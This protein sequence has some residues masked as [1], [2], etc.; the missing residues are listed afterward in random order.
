MEYDNNAFGMLGD[1]NPYNPHLPFVC[2]L[3]EP[4]TDFGYFHPPSTYELPEVSGPEAFPLERLGAGEFPIGATFLENHLFAVPSQKDLSAQAADGI[5]TEQKLGK[6]KPAPMPIPISGNA[7]D[8]HTLA[9]KKK[10]LRLR[11]EELLRSLRAHSVFREHHELFD[12][13]LD[14]RGRKKLMQ[15][16][17]NRISAQESRDRKKNQFNGLVGD[18]IT[19]IQNSMQLERK[20]KEVMAENERLRCLSRPDQELISQVRDILKDSNDYEYPSHRRSKKSMDWKGF[21]V[22]MMAL[23]L[24]TVL[25]PDPRMLNEQ[26]SNKA[27]TETI[28]GGIPNCF[29][30]ITKDTVC[31]IEGLCNKFGLVSGLPVKFDFASKLFGSTPCSPSATA[32]YNNNLVH[33]PEYGSS[34]RSSVDDDL[35]ASF[36]VDL[37]PI[38]A[39]G[40]LSGLKLAMEDAALHS[41]SR[42]KKPDADLLMAFQTEAESGPSRHSADEDLSTEDHSGKSAP[43]FNIANLASII[44]E[45][46]EA[47]D[48]TDAVDNYLDEED[49]DSDGI[50]VAT[51]SEME[52][53]ELPQKSKVVS[54][55]RAQ[56]KKPVK[57][58]AIKNTRGAGVR[59]A[60]LNRRSE[61]VA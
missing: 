49:S 42:L 18:N 1:Y 41:N 24:L 47:F 54:T 58:P 56:A 22:F 51:S 43:N 40:E 28:F 31:K 11:G 52:S 53:E 45:Q 38:P 29:E 17:R 39:K 13:N 37:Q 55:K 2:K 3:E 57:A 8:P 15:K 9:T 14:D 10:K 35:T 23:T 33:T 32:T 48:S 20:L 34:S 26:L 36:L 30:A 27:G 5:P 19:L 61:I 46:F 25:Y 4:E 16:I 50:S 7:K 21:S 59:R 60:S 12:P 6:R 44:K